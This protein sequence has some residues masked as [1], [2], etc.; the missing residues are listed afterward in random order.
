MHIIWHDTD[1]SMARGLEE[2]V[3]EDLRQTMD[4]DHPSDLMFHHVFLTRDLDGPCVFVWGEKGS[5]AFHCEYIEKTEWKTLAEMEAE[6][7]GSTAPTD[8]AKL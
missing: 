5:D 4:V 2:T 3:L 8:D 7:K 1:D 6:E